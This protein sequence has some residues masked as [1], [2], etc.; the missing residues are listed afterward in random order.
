MCRRSDAR[1]PAGCVRRSRLVCESSMF[2]NRSRRKQPG[3]DDASHAS[4]SGTVPL[5]SC[6]YPSGEK[7]VRRVPALRANIALGRSARPIAR[8]HRG[9][10]DHN[11]Q[12]AAVSSGNPASPTPARNRCRANRRTYQCSTQV[13]EAIRNSTSLVYGRVVSLM[14]R[15][16]ASAEADRSPCPRQPGGSV[17]K[18]PIAIAVNATRWSV[19]CGYCGRFTARGRRALKMC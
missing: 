3:L 17:D 7:S 15:P 13:Q 9:I 6:P 12:S 10:S 19:G 1:R 11:R 4:R 8:R 5:N 16:P 2:M 18:R 14:P